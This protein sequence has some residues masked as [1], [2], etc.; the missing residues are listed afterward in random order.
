SLNGRGVTGGTPN[1]LPLLQGPGP[2]DVPRR[3]DVVFHRLFDGIALTPE[4]EAKARD[5]LTQLQTEQVAQD[6]IVLQGMRSW[7][8]KRAVL[9]AQRDSALRALLTSDA[10]RTAFDARIAPPVAG[11]RGTSG[12][13]RPDSSAPGRSGG[14]RGGGD[15]GAGGRGNGGGAGRGSAMSLI[16]DAMFHRLFDGITLTPDQE[17]R[18]R[19]TI[20]KAQQDIQALMPPPVPVRLATRPVLGVVLMQAE[21]ESALVALLTNDADRAALKSHIVVSVPPLAPPQP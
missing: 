2:Q 5:L 11:G 9:L 7:F 19:G 8:P 3:V 14:R 13:P 1:A 20:T 12:A 15:G 4:Q 6:Q 16:V 10:D 21:S 17:A 18:A